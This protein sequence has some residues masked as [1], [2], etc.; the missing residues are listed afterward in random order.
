M[1]K[2]EEELDQT[3]FHH[4]ETPRPTGRETENS[5]RGLSLKAFS[6]DS[7]RGP[8][9]SVGRK[10]HYGR[11][12]GVERAAQLRAGKQKGEEE[13]GVPQRTS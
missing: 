10:P 4:Y 6:S 1:C 13:S 12:C 11:V 5:H 2:A 9:G 7:R 8:G 3:A